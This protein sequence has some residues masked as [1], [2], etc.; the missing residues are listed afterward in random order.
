M[1]VTSGG[2]E[3]FLALWSLNLRCVEHGP[4]KMG[5]FFNLHN[6]RAHLVADIIIL[7]FLH[8]EF[9]YGIPQTDLEIM[10]VLVLNDLG[11]YFARIT[12]ILDLNPKP[13]PKKNHKTPILDHCSR[14]CAKAW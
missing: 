8:A 5:G 2:L 9:C 12:D 3:P 11:P 13:I 1:I 10:L 6:A 7:D 4:S 14:C